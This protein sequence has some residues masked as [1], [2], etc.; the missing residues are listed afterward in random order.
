M[1]ILQSGLIQVEA[2][3]VVFGRSLHGPVD[4]EGYRTAEDDSFLCAN[5]DG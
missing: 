1:L 3:T 2:G 4:A 5:G